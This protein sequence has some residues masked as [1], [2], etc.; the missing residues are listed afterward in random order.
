V[1]IDA[2]TQN[3][4][5]HNATVCWATLSTC[6][7][8]KQFGWYIN[9]P[10]TQEPQIIYSPALRVAGADRELDCTGDQQSYVLH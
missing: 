1:T 6:S 4:D 5:T 9:L 10:G 8:N 3:R 7:G 2:T